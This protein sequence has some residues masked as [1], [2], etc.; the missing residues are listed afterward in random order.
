MVI[1]GS[2]V[3]IVKATWGRLWNAGKALYFYLG[4][5]MDVYIYVRIHWNVR[6]GLKEK[7]W[8]I[9][10]FEMQVIEGASELLKY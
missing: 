3:L 6:L 2:W 9:R 10:A 7:K 1:F 4:G 8:E 5:F